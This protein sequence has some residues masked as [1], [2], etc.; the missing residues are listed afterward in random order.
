MKKINLIPILIILF[1]SISLKGINAESDFITPEQINEDLK[2]TIEKIQSGEITEMN[3]ELL[4]GEEGLPKFYKEIGYVTIWQDPQK[5][6]DAISQ[7]T[8]A[9]KEGLDPLHYHLETILDLQNEIKK[10]PSDKS[11]QVVFDILL[12]R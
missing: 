10:N 5:A 12:K 11:L 2:A 7:L 1:Y 9:W 3:G 8:L 6:N 4:F